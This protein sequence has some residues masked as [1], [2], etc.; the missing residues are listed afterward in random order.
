MAES[1]VRIPIVDEQEK[2][3]LAIFLDK[4]DRTVCEELGIV[5]TAKNSTA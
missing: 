2:R 3:F 1:Q 4:F 5:G